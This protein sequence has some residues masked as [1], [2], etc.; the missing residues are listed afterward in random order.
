[1][2]TN[3]SEKFLNET[4]INISIAQH[5]EFYFEDQERFN[6]NLTWNVSNFTDKVLN[7]SIKFDDPS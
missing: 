4:F 5:D 2:N 3:F 1:M 7:I 6:L